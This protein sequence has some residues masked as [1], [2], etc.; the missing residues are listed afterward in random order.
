MHYLHTQ[1]SMLRLKG[2]HTSFNNTYFKISLPCMFHS[3]MS[4][5]VI[6]WGN[7]RVLKKVFTIQKRKLV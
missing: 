2:N 1:F 3:V 7:L 4:Y 5:V 6:F